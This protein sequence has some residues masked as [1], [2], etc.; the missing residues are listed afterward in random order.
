MDTK[1]MHDGPNSVGVVES[2]ADAFTGR[3]AQ[4]PT[5]RTDRE[6][7]GRPVAR[8]SAV[9]VFHVVKSRRIARR[10][11]HRETRTISYRK[12]RS[13]ASGTHCGSVFGRACVLSWIR[14]GRRPSLQ[15]L[16][17]PGGMRMALESAA[18][19]VDKRWCVKSKPEGGGVP[20]PEGLQFAGLTAQRRVRASET[21]ILVR[22]ILRREE[23]SAA[24][25]HT[26]S[27][28][29]ESLRHP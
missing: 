23:Q 21:S 20:S 16:A 10:C 15:P 2:H 3:P 27:L 22:S 26:W 7:L 12:N 18:L 13:R 19:V 4:F 14:G 28:P 1:L 8:Y 29:E 9:L 6:P 25:L 11:L 17:W 5:E 24:P